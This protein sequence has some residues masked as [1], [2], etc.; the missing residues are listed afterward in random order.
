MK[1]SIFVL[2][3][4]VAAL[5]ASCST[6]TPAVETTNVDSCAVACDTICAP[7]TDTLVVVD[8]TSVN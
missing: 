8:T 7:V 1:K 4:T 5:V 3:I 6:S 2:A